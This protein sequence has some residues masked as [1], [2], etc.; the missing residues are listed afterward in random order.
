M[1]DDGQQR[2]EIRSLLAGGLQTE[3]SPRADT[4]EQRESIVHRLRTQAGDL[5]AKLVIAGFGLKPIEHGGF[6]QHCETCMYFRIHGK[7]CELPELEV[8]VEP[9]WSCRLW[10]I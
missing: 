1:S 8:P 3:V 4:P 9:E 6:V 5:K 2:E 7:H 10:R